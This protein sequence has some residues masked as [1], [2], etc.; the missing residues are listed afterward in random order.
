MIVHI[1]STMQ[2]PFMNRPIVFGEIMINWVGD[3]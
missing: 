1:H 3:D 2:P